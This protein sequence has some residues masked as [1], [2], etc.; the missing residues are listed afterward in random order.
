[1]IIH[2]VFKRNDVWLT[3]FEIK[4][5]QDSKTM[6]LQRA[7]DVEELRSYGL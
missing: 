3:E 5:E 2:D 1:M 7:L 4:G 6:P